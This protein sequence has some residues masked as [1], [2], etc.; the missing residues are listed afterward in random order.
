MDDIERRR[1]IIQRAR[2]MLCRKDREP[3]PEEVKPAQSFTRD[4]NARNSAAWHEWADQ[5]IGAAFDLF[6][7]DGGVLEQRES[8]LTDIFGEELKKT[9]LEIAALKSEIAALRADMTVMQS[10]QRSNN[11]TELKTRDA[12]AA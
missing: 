7:K 6:L 8:L 5:K 4:S 1:E 12:N 2:A 10:I 3:E 11:V 9:D